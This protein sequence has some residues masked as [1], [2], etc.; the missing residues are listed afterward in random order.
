[1]NSVKYGQFEAALRVYYYQRVRTAFPDLFSQDDDSK[2][3]RWFADINWAVY[4]L[5]WVD[6]LYA[7]A[8]AQWPSGVYA[9][10]DIGAGLVALLEKSGYAPP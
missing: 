7:L 10:Q 8:F 1:M 5:D 6:V 3:R 2:V 4:R 9:N